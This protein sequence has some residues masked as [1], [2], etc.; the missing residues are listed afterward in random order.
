MNI[1]CIECG[2][3]I[4]QKTPMDMNYNAEIVIPDVMVDKCP[5]CGDV[6]LDSTACKY[7]ENYLE[8]NHGIEYNRPKRK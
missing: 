3:G 5:I 2:K 8:K 1:T 4:Y 6:V 7:Y